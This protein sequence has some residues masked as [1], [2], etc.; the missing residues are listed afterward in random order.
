[1]LLV[2]NSKLSKWLHYVT[3]F[4]NKNQCCL[5]SELNQMQCYL[6]RFSSPKNVINWSQHFIICQHISSL[7][8]TGKNKAIITFNII[9]TWLIF[10]IDTGGKQTLFFKPHHRVQILCIVYINFKSYKKWS[11]VLNLMKCHEKI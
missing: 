9:N 10:Q 2:C 7:F 3:E 1:M 11:R 8:K 4:Q 5:H 6:A